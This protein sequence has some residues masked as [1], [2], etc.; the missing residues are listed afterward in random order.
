MEPVLHLIFFDQPVS[1]ELKCPNCQQNFICKSNWDNHVQKS[2]TKP[3]SQ[4]PCAFFV[5]KN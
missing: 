4:I 3:E 2:H 5:K 1:P